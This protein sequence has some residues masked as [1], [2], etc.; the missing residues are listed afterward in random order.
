MPQITELLERV[1]QGEP[2]AFDQLIPLVYEELRR[3]ANHRLAGRAPNRTLQ[4]TALVH[5]AYLKLAGATSFDWK[6]SRHFYNAAAEVMKQIVMDHARRS[7]AKKR[8]GER[9]RVEL[10]GV[11]PVDPAGE[12]TDWEALNRA[13]LG[14]RQMDERR[15]QIVMLRYFA[16]LTDKEVAEILDVSE[17]TVERGWA[18]AKVFLRAAME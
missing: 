7:A 2:Q 5:E 17:K 1:N 6:G 10:E 15:Y 16:G 12:A 8:G 11:E 3:R 13:L 9:E 18:A 14:L 4:P